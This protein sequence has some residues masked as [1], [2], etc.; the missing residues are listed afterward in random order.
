MFGPGGTLAGV[1]AARLSNDEIYSVVDDYSNLGRTGET[2]IAQAE[3]DGIVVVA[4]LAATSP[5]P[6]ST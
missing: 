2:V 5:T 1:V 4:P 3:R 6:H